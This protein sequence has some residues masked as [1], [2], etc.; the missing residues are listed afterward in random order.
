MS[1][2]PVGGFTQTQ[3]VADTQKSDTSTLTPSQ[4]LKPETIASLGGQSL[5]ITLLLWMLSYFMKRDRRW[6]RV[7]RSNTKAMTMI[8]D[9]IVSPDSEVTRREIRKAVNQVNEYGDG[10]EA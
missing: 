6:E 10:E 9:A 4:F 8:A 3:D 1:G 5:T 2:G 7:V